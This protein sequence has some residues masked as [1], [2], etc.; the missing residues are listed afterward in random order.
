MPFIFGAGGGQ[1]PVSHTQQQQQSQ[2]N[3]THAD[4][5][6]AVQQM[7]TQQ[8]LQ[9]P[10]GIDMSVLAGIS[11]EQLATIA[12]LF[13]AGALSLPPPP[14]DPANPATS[15]ST[16]PAQAAQQPQDKPHINAAQEHDVDMDKEDGEVEEG[17]VS[18]MPHER[19]FL[20]PPPTGPRNRSA[21]PRGPK[22]KADAPKS[23]P[24][25]AKAN[26][27]TKRTPPQARL[28]QALQVNGT[29]D[30]NS[31]VNKETSAKMFVHEMVKAGKTF[32]DLLPE[33][34]N[35][36]A[37]VRMF[38]QLGLPVPSDYSFNKPVRQN[39]TVA[40]TNVARAA[41]TQ[42][43]TKSYQNGTTAA[44]NAPQPATT[45]S[46][47]TV[48]AASEEARKTSVTKRPAPAKPLDR[49]EYLAR[50]QAAK[51][52]KA[53][54]TAGT[55]T[56]PG[57]IE[58]PAPEPIEKPATP[59][60]APKP[61]QTPAIVAQPSSAGK[62]LDKTELARQRLEALKAMQAARQNGAAPKQ[63]P[64]T[65]SS[66]IPKPAA[67][68]EVQRQYTSSPS[69]S[70]LGAGLADIP[71]RA[72][73]LPSQ[74]SAA[75]P[76]LSLPKLETP[77]TQSAFSPPPLTPAGSIGGLPGLFM[78]GTTA[79]ARP[80]AVPSY[81]PKVP[82]QA[83]PVTSNMTVPQMQPTAQQTPMPLAAPRK[84]PVASDF[85]DLSVKPP[86]AK[87]PF[88]Q[89]RHGSEDES[90]IINVSDDED[91]DENMGGADAGE[92]SVKASAQTKS[93]RDSGPLRDFQPRPTLTRQASTPGT[94][95][96]G[97]P[98]GVTYEQQVK[99]IEKMRRKI[100]EAEKRK[101]GTGKD[102]GVKVK[103]AGEVTD[104]S[105]A[106][107]PVPAESSFGAPDRRPT[108]SLGNVSVVAEPRALDKANQSMP[109]PEAQQHSCNISSI[110][111]VSAATLAKQQ[112]K[113]RLRQRLLELERDEAEDAGE[114]GDAEAVE[115]EP[116]PRTNEV[117]ATT[118]LTAEKAAPTTNEMEAGEEQMER[119]SAAMSEDG[120]L[121][122]DSVSKLYEPQDAQDTR[123]ERAVS[124]DDRNIV[125]QAT[126]VSAT[127]Q[128]ESE[129][130]LIVP[131]SP[132]TSQ[133]ETDGINMGFGAAPAAGIPLVTSGQTDFA[134][135]FPQDTEMTDVAQ[136]PRDRLESMDEGEI[137]SDEDDGDLDSL[138]GTAS[139][140]QNQLHPE[141]D[142][143]INAKDTSAPGDSSS[144][145]SDDSGDFEPEPASDSASMDREANDPVIAAIS[146]ASATELLTESGMPDD[147]LAKELQPEVQ[148]EQTELSNQKP[149]QSKPR[150]EPYE[151]PLKG[152]KD[153]RWHPDYLK[154]VPGGFKSLTYNH[155][156]DSV[157]PLCFFEA[158]G[159]KCN[160]R[161]CQNQHF[162]EMGL[163]ENEI[164]K[165]LG[166]N[167]IPAHGPEEIK[168][169]NEG[170]GGLI[171]HMR[172]TNVGKSVDAIAAELSKFRREFTGDSTKVVNLG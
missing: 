26:Q 100:A 152:F 151:S 46:S 20:R 22:A 71:A 99:E 59:A 98:G 160:D 143:V 147:D 44:V 61:L 48:P 132:S 114:T 154:E 76:S 108:P 166:T 120:E 139:R 83:V 17:E 141:D 96:G 116:E 153:F 115:P 86:V 33:I 156:I 80:P 56:A 112:E 159:G 169:W 111:P 51:N 53:E 172:S 161:G 149:A 69:Q 37:L 75:P 119:G 136:E 85:D 52:K 127:S 162:R 128:E 142:I 88:G 171:K 101:K 81:S 117:P 131:A 13:Q 118:P 92:A 28:G 23:S 49:N 146:D 140:K 72:A 82:Q 65:R 109:P 148:V 6:A 12:R 47:A 10:A 134:E 40:A 43:S 63:T 5:S 15:V 94:P 78:M 135:P 84:R 167:N 89:S 102:I 103:E 97:T 137:D 35:P 25:V 90:V 14:P 95:G 144:V 93:F 1:P 145:S 123:A 133:Q 11:P 27:T 50:L 73:A 36:K 158:A 2:S 64:V 9:L 157:K 122:D 66:P 45:L 7:A 29:A 165:K 126:T 8:N 138:N 124:G 55:A 41:P 113:E 21:S 60:E 170:L 91:E 129:P 32:E 125:S 57:P 163:S 3:R 24:R 150:Y 155:N 30:E 121:S 19:D 67:L 164:I 4:Q 110:R 107:T 68:A 31:R 38:N 74:S 79:Q 70:G 18:T 104:S 105:A 54:A 16:S 42:P 77:A 130:S 39:G 106:A 62:V 168:R 58:T 87:R 34:S